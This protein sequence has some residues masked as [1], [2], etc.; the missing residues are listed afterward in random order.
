MKTQDARTFSNPP[1]WAQR[2]RQ[3]VEDLRKG[4]RPGSP[5]EGLRQ[6]IELADIGL[7]QI[8]SRLCMQFPDLS[9]SQIED[10]AYTEL[11]QWRQIRNRLT[12]RRAH[13]DTRTSI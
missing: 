5:E 4:P 9:L 8:L 1:L 7:Q 11:E 13:A 10:R 2:L 12:F 3:S 6:T